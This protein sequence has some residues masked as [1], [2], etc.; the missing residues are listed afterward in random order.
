MEIWVVHA[1][2]HHSAQLLLRAVAVPSGWTGTPWLCVSIESVVS[3]APD[4]EGGREVGGEAAAAT[5]GDE[6]R[7]PSKAVIVPLLS[8][9]GL[10]TSALKTHSAVDSPR[11]TWN[12]EAKSCPDFLVRSVT[13]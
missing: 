3:R 5:W 2:S 7:S 9:L 11:H 1:L 8:L 13:Y 10:G 6:G 4:G 12:K